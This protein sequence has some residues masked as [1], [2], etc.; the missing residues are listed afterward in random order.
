MC[1]YAEDLTPML[2]ILARPESL[3]RLR[4]D[5]AV[6]LTKVRVF[7]LEDDG[8]FPLITS[9]H[10]ELRRAQ[11]RLLDMLRG[12]LGVEVVRAKLPNMF[13]SLPIWTE[14]MASEP[15]MKSFCAELVQVISI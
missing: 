7:Y 8:G 15:T 2:K 5:S 14:S 6:D 9:V 3:S 1:R 12:E 4:L 13:Y 11:S 10:S